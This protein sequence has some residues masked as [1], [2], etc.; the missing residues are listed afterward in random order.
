MEKR[1]IRETLNNSW[2][3]IFVLIVLAITAYFGW[4]V[5]CEKQNYE[6]VKMVSQIET[7]IR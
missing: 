3:F 7:F 1:K 5:Y 2:R 6:K 4:D